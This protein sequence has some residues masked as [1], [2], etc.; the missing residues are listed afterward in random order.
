MYN[1][2]ILTTTA[3]GHIAANRREDTPRRR[4]RWVV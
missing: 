3:G 1:S 4:C 2:V